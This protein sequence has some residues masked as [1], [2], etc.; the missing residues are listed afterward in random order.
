MVSSTKFIVGFLMHSSIIQFHYPAS[1]QWRLL[2]TIHG[3]IRPHK[4]WLVGMGDCSFWYNCW[5]GFCPLF[6]YNPA[7]A[8]L[9]PISFYWQDTVWDRG[10]LKDILPSSIV[11]QILLAPISYGEPDLIRWDLGPDGTFHLRTAWELV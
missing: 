8:S 6:L 3:T 7:A 11:E 2:Y 10:R 1:H 5:L 9:V 4:L